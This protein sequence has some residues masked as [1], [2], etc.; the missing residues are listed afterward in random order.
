M[1]RAALFAPTSV[2]ALPELDALAHAE[3]LM[4]M[5]ALHRRDV[6]S[7]QT[8]VLIGTAAHF[9]GHFS[10]S[11][12]YLD[13]K[14][15]P[16]DRWSQRVLPEMAATSG[17]IDVLYPF[18]GPPYQ[19]FIAWAKQSGAAFDSP[20]GMLVHAEAGMMISY[21]GALVFEGHLTLPPTPHASP[22]DRCEGRPC[23]AACPV[24]ALSP[25]HFYDVPACKAHI[26]VPAGNDC[27][28]QGCAVRRACPV[29]QRFARAQDQ[30]AHH[31]RAF[32]GE[33]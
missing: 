5:G 32:L 19:P 17:A 22:C 25:D 6:A 11:R 33:S 29:S 16:I 28:V 24:N 8:L 23:E 12:E 9:W 18:G 26:A 7:P 15:D 21:R 27:M 14:S 3:G 20:L 2:T 13:Q 4:P 1:A 30:S 31:M 10:Q